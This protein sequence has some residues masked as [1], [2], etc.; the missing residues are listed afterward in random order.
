MARITPQVLNDRLA[1]HGCPGSIAVGSPAWFAWLE[2]ARLFTFRGPA[3]MFTARR[4]QRARGGA[5]WRAYRT[6]G[7]RQRRAY[8]GRSTDLTPTRLWAVAV[9]LT[10]DLPTQPPQDKP[11]PGAVTP[12]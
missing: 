12:V 2:Q 6:V 3:G 11:P 4:E 1:D 7:G 8:L 10:A 9:Q 5:Y